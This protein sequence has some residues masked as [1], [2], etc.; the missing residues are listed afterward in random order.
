MTNT[1]LGIILHSISLGVPLSGKN[2][3]PGEF[4]SSRFADPY[5]S[6]NT[7][8]DQDLDSLSEDF[9]YELKISKEGDSLI[10]G[11]SSESYRIL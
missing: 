2:P 5:T 3:R 9:L 4:N 1:R 11:S 10:R 7:Q 6:L 8:E